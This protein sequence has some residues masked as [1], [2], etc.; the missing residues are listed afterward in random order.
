MTSVNWTKKDNTKE[1]LPSPKAV[2]AYNDVMVAVRKKICEMVV[3]N[4]LFCY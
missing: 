1:E 4:L 2:A 3:S